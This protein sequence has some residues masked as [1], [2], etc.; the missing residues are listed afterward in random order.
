MN[1]L[2]SVKGLLSQENVKLKFEEILKD[3]ANG[4]IANLAVMVSSSSA[5]AKCDPMSVVSAAVISASLD[6]PLDPNL[7][8]AAIVPY[9]SSAQFQMMYKGFVQLAMRTGQYK[10]IGVTEIYDGQ[11]IK[12]NPLT[13]EFIFDFDAKESEK[14][15]GF[16]AYFKLI[17]GFE[18][19][20]YWPIDKIEKHGKRYSK[21]F[22]RQNG[23]W[24]EDFNSMASKTVLKHLISKWGI[25][26]IEMQTA[27]KADQSV[28]KGGINEDAEFSYIDNDAPLDEK[29][30]DPFKNEPKDELSL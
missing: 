20:V 17:N 25:L 8:F 26:S 16:A 30:A 19:T 7:G 6:L 2:V 14:V 15:I 11:L 1:Q 28:I 5:L 3:R 29:P 21:S 9:G 13:S 10:T 18:K 23:R 4:F 27:V 24:Q 22:S 12:Q